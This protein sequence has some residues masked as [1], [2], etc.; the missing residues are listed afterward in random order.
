MTAIA[1]TIAIAT[2]YS[3]VAPEGQLGRGDTLRQQIQTVFRQQRPN[4]QITRDAQ[5]PQESLATFVLSTNGS[6]YGYR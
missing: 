3:A 2:L 6:T 1:M 5:A 4:L